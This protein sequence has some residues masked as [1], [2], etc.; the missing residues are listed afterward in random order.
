M[1]ICFKPQGTQTGALYQPGGVGR[2][3][4]WEG[5]DLRLI[6]V[7]VWQKTTQFCKTIILQLKINKNLKNNSYHS[8]ALAVRRRWRRWSI[9]L[10]HGAW[11]REPSCL[12]ARPPPPP[13]LR[14]QEPG[15]GPGTPPAP[16]H[17]PSLVVRPR[18]QRAPASR[19]D[20]ERA[21]V[22]REGAAG[23]SER[24]R[25]GRERKPWPASSPSLSSLPR[26]RPTPNAAPGR[27]QRPMS[28]KTSST[29]TTTAP[30]KPQK[31][32][33]KKQLNMLMKY[34]MKQT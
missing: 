32:N 34:K 11:V 18:G 22:R 25:V 30:T 20:S 33:S 4:R 29:P 15:P 26:S 10:E 9:E 23:P 24:P 13:L 7:E 5:G 21:E 2:D 12:P 16:H 27:R 19:S 17:S 14:K 3:G 6:H 28:V 8:F 1:G 31:K